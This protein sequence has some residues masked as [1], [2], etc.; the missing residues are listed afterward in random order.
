[1]C[2]FEQLR[3][4]SADAKGSPKPKAMKTDSKAKLEPLHQLVDLAPIGEMSKSML[5]NMAPYSLVDS[6][7][8][9]QLKTKEMLKGVVDMVDKDHAE[10]FEEAK[11]SLK[12]NQSELEEATKTVATTGEEATAAKTVKQ[13]KAEALQTAKK[14]VSTAKEEVAAAKRKEESLETER[15][16]V[17]AEGAE[18]EGVLEKEWAVLKAGSLD[19]KK[20]RERAK[21][22]DFVLKMLEPSGL[23]SALA[24]ALPIAFKTKPAERGP[25]AEKAITYAEDLLQKAVIKLRERLNG[26]EA[27]ASARSKAVADAEDVLQAALK[28]EEQKK[29][30]YQA[31]QENESEKAL[32]LSSAKKTEKA[33]GPKVKKAEAALAE[34][35]SGLEEVRKLAAEFKQLIE[36][37]TFSLGSSRACTLQTL[38]WAVDFCYSSA[39]S[40]GQADSVKIR[41]DPDRFAT[42]SS[43]VGLRLCST[44]RSTSTPRS[45]S[46]NLSF[47]PVLPDPMGT[48]GVKGVSAALLEQQSVLQAVLGTL[49]RPV[50]HMILLNADRRVAGPAKSSHVAR[51]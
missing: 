9:F 37:G 42:T 41:T 33:L 14:E 30:E 51:R 28:T 47:C 25:F 10:K 26:F 13:E 32:A 50:C 5:L 1:M 49:S 36:G 17:V 29:E 3:F 19:G 21:H 18:Y 31:A 6:P 43:S 2:G 15:A 8:E 22:I 23:D 7:H 20:W 46:R 45:F 12:S 39:I 40:S 44:Q 4:W 38:Q 27:E 35:E 11:A 16:A 48:E 34:A 24:G